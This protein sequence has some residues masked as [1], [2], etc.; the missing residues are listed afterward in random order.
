MKEEKNKKMFRGLAYNIISNSKYEYD[1]ENRYKNS[2][3]KWLE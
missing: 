1:M 2:T 3:S